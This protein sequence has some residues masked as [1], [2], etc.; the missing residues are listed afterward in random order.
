MV[1]KLLYLLILMSHETNSLHSQAMLGQSG[2]RYVCEYVVSSSL[3]YDAAYRSL[4][5]RM[6]DGLLMLNFMGGEK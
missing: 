1:I 4:Q 2:V 6:L 5:Q 3:L